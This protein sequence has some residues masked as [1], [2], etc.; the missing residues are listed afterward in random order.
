MLNDTVDQEFDD[1]PN[2]IGKL[3]C[4]DKIGG[5]I[6]YITGYNFF[7]NSKSAVISSPITKAHT[8]V[9]LLK[10]IAASG[11]MDFPWYSQRRISGYFRQ[12]NL[13]DSLVLQAKEFEYFAAL[14]T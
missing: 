10:F 4:S 3:D 1:N 13:D 2:Q 11:R 14:L 8:V 7:K 5:V 9:L 6:T 12:A